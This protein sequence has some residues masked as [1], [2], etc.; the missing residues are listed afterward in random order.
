MSTVAVQR[1]LTPDAMMQG[2]YEYMDELEAKI[3][4]RAFSLFESNGRIDGHDVCDWLRAESE[5]LVPVPLEII[6]TETELAVRA[7]VPGFNEKELEVVAEP[8]RVFIRGKAEK[9]AEEKK[10]K[11]IYSEITSNEIFRSLALPVEID[12]EKVT[13]TLKNGVL[14]IST[15]KAKPAKKVSVMQKVA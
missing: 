7:E 1:V 12:P 9:K 4:K 10:K 13:A 3:S 6:E 2:L 15:N 11:T 14:E 8:G 5:F